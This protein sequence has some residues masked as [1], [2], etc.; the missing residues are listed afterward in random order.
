MKKR[1]FFKNAVILTV[2]MLLLRTMNIGYR[3][4]LSNKIGAAGM[5]LFQLIL[6]VF[7]L[8]ITVSVSGIS[9][10]VTRL[11]T[12]AA[13]T[14][15]SGCA[16]SIIRKC[17][18]FS[19]T[20]SV[21][22]MVAL[23]FSADFLAANFLNDCRAALPL[24]ILAPG[25]PF[26]SICACLKGY[27]LAI[28][29]MMK[30]AS[31]EMLEQLVTIGIVVALFVYFSPQGLEN[32]C[33]A[34]MLGSTAGELFSFGYTFLLYKIS[35]HKLKCT[36]EKST[37]I[38][39]K[40]IHIGLPVTF[41]STLRSILS[42]AENILIPIG[43]KKNGATAESSLSQYGMIQGMVMPILFFPSA[44][45]AAFSSL[46]I[47]EMAEANAAGKHQTIGRTTSRAMQLTLLF[48]VFTASVFIAF[49]KDLGLAFYQ[50]EQA[51]VILRVLAPLVPLMYLDS[52]VD[53]ILKGLD[54][55]LSSLKYNF[56]DSVL[57]VLLIYFAIPFAG[58]KGYICVLFFST[59]FNAT[60]SINRLIKV[61]KVQVQLVS[62]VFKPI[63]C[64]ALAALMVLIFCK[65]PLLAAL[66]E[67]ECASMQVVLSALLYYLFLRLCGSFTKSDVI[68][69]KSI[70]K[71]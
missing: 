35:I 13:A 52:V 56:S 62:W 22:A 26:M 16:K 49:S 17:I 3:V 60:L 51:G 67:W 11:V 55:Q 15:K 1:V 2:T 48:S 39:R 59:I 45:L 29:D 40:I 36:K 30:P 24:K 21:L 23:Y 20:L 8:A 71:Q 46:L 33:C 18:A 69:V 19:F 54:Q 38:F 58:T 34:I 14:G 64:A 65:L 68:W 44:F 7:V 28:R 25:L 61:S 27:F 10:V 12:E 42:T 53:S 47:P 57:R 41:S 4:Y 70:F 43:F 63:I 9:L 5:G 66:S 50:N 31:G 6:S 37:G 32:A